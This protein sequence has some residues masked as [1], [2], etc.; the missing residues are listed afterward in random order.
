VTFKRSLH[1]WLYS[2]GTP[3]A[4]MDSPSDTLQVPVGGGSAERLAEQRLRS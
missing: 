1:F 2:F 3:S 4:M